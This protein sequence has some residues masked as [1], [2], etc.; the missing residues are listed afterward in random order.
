[1]N[2]FRLRPL[3]CVLALCSTYAS[4]DEPSVSDAKAKAAALHLLNPVRSSAPKE[5]R[6]FI[7]ESLVMYVGQVSVINTGT[8]DRVA[9]GNGKVA[10]STVLDKNRLLIIAQDVG[11]TN[12]LLWDKTK[13]VGNLKL[14]VTAVDIERQKREVA[15]MLSD[16]PQLTIA[17]AGDRIFVDGSELSPEQQARVKSA[18]EQYPMLTDRTRGI[19]QTEKPAAPSTMVM[20]DLYF[21][22]F[23][24]NHLQNLGVNWTKSFN[25][26][27]FG[28]F[29][30][31]T[32]GPLN[33][34]PGIGG[35]SGVTYTPPL[36]NT[37]INGL[38][39]ALNVSVSVPAM[40]NLAVNNGDA[41][42]LAA[43]KLAVRSG[44]AAKFLAGGEFP[45][46]MTG[47]TGN[48]VQYKQYGIILEVEPKVNADKT[49]SGVIKAEV[50]ALDPTVSVNGY[51]GMSKRRTET[52]FHSPLGEA[53]V[54]S[55]LYSQELSGAIDKLP[56]LGDIPLINSL[57]S[58][59]AETRKNTE[60]VVFIVPRAHSS[61]E[62]L[63]QEVISRA[64][65][66]ST[67]RNTELAGY[68]ILPK[69]TIESSLWKGREAEFTK[70]VPQFTIKPND[71]PANDNDYR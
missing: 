14:R 58:S 69:L 35:E 34:R 70:V 4:A 43:P 47:I 6:G 65:D 26:F 33:L 21:L 53:I 12:L 36:P 42:L 68:D 27:N 50:S 40:I 30:E 60:L 18:K 15:A 64:S 52:D 7:E 57:F 10:S 13:P 22:E 17:S 19:L 61:E 11:E 16:V 2:Y 67:E 66:L 62:S 71:Y 28:A 29:G 49:V 38:S 39:T 3:V 59:K 9:L 48:T 25:G 5:K 20:F 1:M 55:G 37:K 44:G 31:T 51:P 32:N 54:L 41:T 63:N 8:I 46:V 45:I 23:K 56:V 24:K